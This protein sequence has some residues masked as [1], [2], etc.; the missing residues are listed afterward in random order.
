MICAW[1]ELLSVI[2]M[3]FRQE[4]DKRGRDS[5]LELRM[6]LGKPP[7]LVKML[8]S[9][10]L[11][12]PV[13]ES[14]IHFT[15]NTASRYSPWSAESSRDGYITA[16]GGHRIGICGEC[17][18]SEGTMSGVRRPT[19]LCIRVARDI[20]GIA[21]AVHQIKG[22][23]LILGPPGSGKTTLLRDLIRQ[24]SNHCHGCIAV[25]DERCEIFPANSNFTD[26]P[27]T[28]VLSGCEKVQGIST[29]LRTLGPTWIAVDEI[30]A[31][32]DG[33]ALLEAG[34]CGVKLLATAHASNKNDLF[35]RDIYCQLVKSG[36][37]HTIIIL[38]QDKSWTLERLSI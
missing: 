27:C 15:I 28:D 33:E 6:R 12:A 14:D 29:A 5:M 20:Q 11:S 24:I 26:G 9:E 34:W 17:I 19:S 21:P 38:N 30:T 22:S 7:Q 32:K 25:V 36:L 2:P 4:V 13:T 1:N 16:K 3:H 35:R 37:F 18:V 10:W 8:C 31:Q 23:V